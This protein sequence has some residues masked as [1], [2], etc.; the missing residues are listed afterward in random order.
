VELEWLIAQSVKLK[1]EVVSA[2]EHE[3]VCA[4]FSS[5]PYH[6]M[7]WKPKPATSAYFTRS[8]RLGMIAATNIA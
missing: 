5:R 4:A 7:R 8:R 3:E 2:D 6:R 1:A